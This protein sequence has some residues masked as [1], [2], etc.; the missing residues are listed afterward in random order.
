MQ[1]V[2]PLRKRQKRLHEKQGGGGKADCE[3]PERQTE[4]RRRERNSRS[5]STADQHQQERED[6]EQTK[7]PGMAEVARRTALGDNACTG[8]ETKPDLLPDRRIP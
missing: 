7:T 3:E 6:E 2:K 4:Q 5:N 8:F 1:G